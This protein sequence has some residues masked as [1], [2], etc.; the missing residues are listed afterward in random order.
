MKSFGFLIMIISFGLTLPI[1]QT[2][3][4]YHKENIKVFED[5][6]SVGLWDL[7]FNEDLYLYQGFGSSACFSNVSCANI[8]LQC[9][10][11]DW[12]NKLIC[13]GQLRGANSTCPCGPPPLLCYKNKWPFDNTEWLPESNY[14][15]VEVN[16]GITDV[17]Y[18]PNPPSN[19]SCIIFKID[20]LDGAIEGIL[21]YYGELWGGADGGPFILS[22]HGTVTV[23][24]SDPLWGQTHL[25]RVFGATG[26]PYAKVKISID[27]KNVPKPHNFN[28]CNVSTELQSTHQCL[29]VGKL[30]TLSPLQGSN[31]IRIVVDPPNNERCGILG[32]WASSD[33]HL[34]STN[35]WVSIQN[36]TNAFRSHRESSYDGRLWPSIYPYCLQPNEQLYIFVLSNV[37]V[38]FFID[39]SNEWMILR[40]FSEFAPPDFYKRALGTIT[41]VCGGKNFT[42]HNKVYGVSETMDTGS[43]N[44]RMVY[45]SDDL[46]IF[47]PSP[48]FSDKQYSL[49][50]D[51]PIS[52]F[53]PKKIIVSLILN[54]RLSSRSQ[55]SV[56]TK[57]W[58]QNSYE[59]LTLDQWEECNLNINGVV[60]VNG[61]PLRL[62]IDGTN[63]IINKGLPE[64][65]VNLYASTSEN[66]NHIQKMISELVSESEIVLADIYRLWFL[67]DRLISS[68]A[69][70]SCKQ[71]I[72]T[73]YTTSIDLPKTVT[74][75]ECVTSF[76]SIEE[77]NNDTCCKLEKLSLYDKCVSQERII[78]EQ[79]KIE[80]FT[81]GINNC[82]NSLQCAKSSLTNFLLQ[83]NLE[84][85]PTACINSV[86]R[87][88]D[89]NAYWHCIHKIWGPEPVTFAGPNCT[90]DIDCP[91]SKC[92]IYSKRCSVDIN[93][94][95]YELISCI[96]DKASQFA[97]TFIS[98][99][100]GLDPTSPNIKNL[101]LNT[102]SQVLPCSDPFVPVGFDLQLASYGK[103]Y[104]CDKYLPNTTNYQSNWAFSPGP[105][106]A[107]YGY[108]CW[109]P[110]SSSCS[111]TTSKYSAKSFCGV[112]GCNNI[113][114]SERAFFPFVTSS[115]YCV[116]N[117]FCGISDDGFFYN[118]ITD[119][120]SVANCGTS[121]ILCV[122]ANGT[123][124][125]T[126]DEKSCN[127]IFS[128][129]V[130]CNGSEC[131][132]E[133]NCKNSGSCSD[134]NDYDIGIW[135]NLYEKE[136]AGCFF[137]I[138]YLEPFNPT[139]EV[140]EPPFHNTIIGCSVTNG[141]IYPGTAPFPINESS[142]ITGNFKWGDSNIFELINPRWIK[143]AE[144]KMECLNYGNVCDD[145]SN[146][147]PAGISTYTNTL[148]FNDEC[149]ISRKLFS[150]SSGR[151]L[152]GQAR[153]AKQVVGKLTMRFS[154]TSRI[155][156]NIPLILS[157]LTKAVNKL[158]S[159]KIQST[160]FCRSS[161]KRYL[162][163]LMCSCKYVSNNNDS[164]CYSQTTNI[165]TI[166][167]A[168]DSESS[169][170]AGN[171]QISLSKTS[172]PL[173]TCDNLLITVF[174][175]VTY[176]SRSIIPLRTLLVNYQ[177][178]TEYAIRNKQLGI[179]GKVLT[180]GYSMRFNTKITN[181][182]FCIKLSVLRINYESQSS[183]YPIL[184]IAKRSA[185]S[186]PDNLIPLNLN[187]TFDGDSTFCAKLDKFEANQIF[188]FIQRM[189]MDYT[190]VQ[191]TVF[192]SGEIAYIAVL[193]VLYCFGEIAVIIKSSYLFYVYMKTKDVGFAPFRFAWVLFL[194]GCFFAFRIVLFSLLLNNGLLGSSSTKAIGYVLFEFPILLFFGFVINY[195]CIWITS[196]IFIN[197]SINNHQ[198]MSANAN[199]F[200][201]LVNLV[202]LIL[203]VVMVILF[204][205]LIFEPYLICG[206]SILLYDELKS[207]ALL[208]SYRIIFSTIAI[209]LGISVFAT[210]I[211]FGNLLS[212]PEYNLSVMT[213][214]K[215]Y[216]LSIAGGFGMVGQ[217][218][219]FLIVTTTQ[220][221]P[222]NYASLTIVLILEI[223]PAL[224]FVFVESIKDPKTIHDRSP[225]AISVKSKK[226]DSSNV[227]TPNID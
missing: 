143:R 149:S 201:I 202:L 111:I 7:T 177:E 84:V 192:S 126:S 5:T 139:T 160:A 6:Y 35:V 49:I 83:L 15:I 57:P 162:D 94:A 77:F 92:N 164:V 172:L 180:D 226:T 116:N 12:T 150:W 178:D 122:L 104:G 212:D 175:I 115:S 98:N 71:E 23:C 89:Q 81:D 2:A 1:L 151:W 78:T 141:Q 213:R 199:Y 216:L 55:P 222:V 14:T 217:A 114:Y 127:N 86:E 170:S 125:Q 96:Y 197:K 176:Q 117:T 18:H 87:P 36:S 171:L 214:V 46:D 17:A 100:L 147:K 80:K 225:S 41:A 168:C 207:F 188:H 195:V 156:L 223:I 144:N 110:G 19:C 155:G 43:A 128:C 210:A 58:F 194:M 11:C 137:T 208:L 145:P 198:R 60:D 130:N 106:W 8:N 34:L 54:Q 123:Q 120:I 107:S 64:C 161:Y 33:I 24:P 215:L 190:M 21:L 203:F 63:S 70:Y 3:N 31:F 9:G 219:Y 129:D 173:A 179:Y 136:T 205:T 95:E 109:A 135:T 224:L 67:Q 76:N 157:N 40:S 227:N 61:K 20:V 142:C 193:L 206:N 99:E 154:N 218:I 163:E 174:S 79:Y 32:F 138:R 119:V 118:D 189:D 108:N 39:T 153:I 51:V 133:I 169:I 97:R 88:N 25:V 148:F 134:A 75:N 38:Q 191:R 209:I 52:S 47:Y 10:P 166:S 82:S 187:I 44:I 69:F 140:C 73:Y 72:Q 159:L 204:E 132:D 74:T 185:D 37:A 27:Y 105:S 4:K 22:R 200:S 66:I 90:H 56:W 59:W 182:T 45:P 113:A 68:N 220:T 152:P 124:I 112:L 62:E 50:K 158:E 184:D 26:I 103:C 186:L 131:L 16:N 91:N 165:T 146:P 181:I 196:I 85:D 93:D 13:S 30:T 65:D 53:T 121:A 48:F 167:V 28:T 102:F 29:P 221:T 183:K 211:T 101:W 42:A